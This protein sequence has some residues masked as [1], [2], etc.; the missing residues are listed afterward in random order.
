MKN[1]ALYMNSIIFGGP[2]AQIQC[3][4]MINNDFRT[5]FNSFHCDPAKAAKITISM[6]IIFESPQRPGPLK[7][8]E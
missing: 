1:L 4:C 2:G 7:M 8:Q 3:K 6:W 5:N